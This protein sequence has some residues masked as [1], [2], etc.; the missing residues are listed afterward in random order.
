M[1][2]PSRQEDFAREVY[3][4][5]VGSKQRLGEFLES[6]ALDKEFVQDQFREDGAFGNALFN[7][8]FIRLTRHAAE[9]R[10][11]PNGEDGHRMYDGLLEL[12]RRGVPWF[13]SAA[14]ILG[15]GRERPLEENPILSFHPWSVRLRSELVQAGD[16]FATTPLVKVKRELVLGGGRSHEV[17]ADLQHLNSYLDNIVDGTDADG[18]EGVNRGL[19]SAFFFCHRLQLLWENQPT[20]RDRLE[21]ARREIN[22][23]IRRRPAGSRVISNALLQI[24][25]TDSI[26]LL[27]KVARGEAVPSR[28]EPG[29][30]RDP[31]AATVDSLPTVFR[32]ATLPTAV[33]GDRPPGGLSS[34]ENALVS[35][36]FL[37]E[38]MHTL[39]A[40]SLGLEA[41]CVVGYPKFGDSSEDGRLV[42]RRVRYL[43]RAAC[44]KKPEIENWFQVF[45]E[46]PQEHQKECAKMLFRSE[47]T[48][49][50]SQ[51]VSFTE[52]QAKCLMD[53]EEDSLFISESDSYTS[54]DQVAKAVPAASKELR[55][56]INQRLFDDRSERAERT[57]CGKKRSEFFK[58]RVRRDEES[59][60]LEEVLR[61][62]I[63]AEG[64]S[65]LRALVD[66]SFHPQFQVAE[67]GDFLKAK[68]FNPAVDPEKLEEL[69]KWAR[70]YYRAGIVSTKPLFDGKS[71]DEIHKEV[72]AGSHAPYQSHIPALHAL[73][74]DSVVWPPAR[75]ALQRLYRDF[76]KEPS[77]E[78]LRALWNG[79]KDELDGCNRSRA[80]LY[81]YSCDPVLFGTGGIVGTA[82]QVVHANFSVGSSPCLT[83]LMAAARSVR[84]NEEGRLRCLEDRLQVLLGGQ[85]IDHHDG[86]GWRAI[87]HAFAFGNHSVAKLL[88]KAG[89]R[90]GFVKG[91]KTT[92]LIE[93]LRSRQI[94]EVDDVAV[95]RLVNLAVTELRNLSAADQQSVLTLHDNH[96][97]K[98]RCGDPLSALA[99]AVEAG[100]QYSLA[101]LQ[102]VE[103]SLT[104]GRG[105]WGGNLDRFIKDRFSESRLGDFVAL[106]ENYDGFAQK[107]ADN[108]GKLGKHVCK[109]L[110]DQISKDN[111]VDISKKLEKLVRIKGV[112]APK[113]VFH[114]LIQRLVAERIGHDRPITEC[115]VSIVRDLLSQDGASDRIVDEKFGE[116]A[117]RAAWRSGQQLVALL[118]ADKL[119]STKS[120]IVD[121]AQFLATADRQQMTVAEV[122]R[123]VVE[124]TGA[125]SLKVPLRSGA[126]EPKVY[127]LPSDQTV[128]AAIKFPYGETEA[129]KWLDDFRADIA[130]GLERALQPTADGSSPLEFSSKQLMTSRPYAFEKLLAHL[131]D[132]DATRCE[133]DPTPSEGS[134]PPAPTGRSS[135]QEVQ[136]ST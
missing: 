62:D 128:S 82:G 9:R 61:G 15:C 35:R 116:T 76:C 31:K 83:P 104:G 46:A 33:L 93:A 124:P 13:S 26:K 55:G 27:V 30:P 102:T 60:Y 117:V 59:N 111:L 95:S 17:Q 12:I 36:G 70:V 113:D 73:L 127:R 84:D 63:E 49:G 8:V 10:T 101:P 135:E 87:H 107:L 119:A 64:T 122:S 4:T 91:D 29:W 56:D 16:T 88:L 58:K 69:S 131:Y 39:R 120:Q 48:S 50:V 114:T 19:V 118:M 65:G 37:R 68:E 125:V 52:D 3:E 11:D 90:V 42:Q 45:G 1:T 126:E 92:V 77:N 74:L 103:Q 81:G 54:L 80:L 108:D 130:A 44:V 32:F 86:R 5:I 132:K 22:N 40:S 72:M 110:I 47:A 94:A 133:D 66:S 121:A 21:R 115:V 14:K 96:P 129:Q 28:A 41:G 123:L 57:R 67:I 112:S 51:G 75:E 23:M 43:I 34:D 105:V 109:R 53:I 24:A 25:V 106:I 85:N 2:K 20:E 89:A 38:V 79:P 134:A 97:P 71:S 98:V 7:D 99:V 136:G 18:T 100:A 6:Q 78:K